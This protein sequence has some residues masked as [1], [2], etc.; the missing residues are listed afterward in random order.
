MKAD[1]SSSL[2][3]MDVTFPVNKVFLFSD[4]MEVIKQMAEDALPQID[5]S[6]YFI[7]VNA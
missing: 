4:K 1:G 7:L 2:D 5:E 3:N 6:F